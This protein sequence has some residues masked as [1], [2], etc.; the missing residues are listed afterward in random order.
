MI[1]TQRLVPR[2][3]WPLVAIAGL[4][5]GLAPTP[6]TAQAGARID[7]SLRQR[8]GAMSPTATASVIVTVRT[9]AKPAVC[10]VMVASGAT[11]TREFSIIEAFAA[12]LSAEALQALA[13]DARVLAISSDGTVEANT[14]TS[15]RQGSGRTDHAFRC[16]ADVAGTDVDSNP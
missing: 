14:A 2:K 10:R 1:P 7:S 5:L 3:K 9:G 12:R 8:L 16:P 11:I 4:L 6:A 13:R 15:A